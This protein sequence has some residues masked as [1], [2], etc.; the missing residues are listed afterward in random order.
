MSELHESGLMPILSV[1]IVALI[2]RWLPWPAKYHPLIFAALMAERMANK[3]HKKKAGSRLEQVIAGT[4]APIVLLSP[5]LLIFWILLA[6]AEYPVFFDSLL[7]LA[8]LRFEYVC[9]TCRKIRIALNQDKKI[10]ARQLLQPLVLRSTHNLSSFGLAKACIETMLLRFSHQYCSVILLYLLGGGLLA[11]SYRLLYEFGQVWHPKQLSFTIFGQPVQRLM[12]CLQWLPAIISSL[13]FMLALNIWGG[14]KSIRSGLYWSC[15]R[16]VILNSQGGSLNLQLGGPA[17]Y[18]K[19][20]HRL[21]KC[22]GQRKVDISDIQRVLTANRHAK[23]V[24]LTLC[25]VFSLLLNTYY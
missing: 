11:V 10:L 21:T 2:E 18:A 9:Q 5:F 23:W 14:L 3:V 8:A 20:K 16:L 25:F 24:F 4:L 7:L 13:C 17:F 19:Q 12:S 1:L 22:G 6:L 15:S